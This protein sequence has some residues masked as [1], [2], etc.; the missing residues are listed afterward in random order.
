MRLAARLAFLVVG[1][2]LAV[3]A[4]R[5]GARRPGVYSVQLH[6][7]GPFSEGAGSIDSHSHEARDVGCD[8][9]W[10]SEHD[11]RL[12]GYGLVARFGFEDWQEPLG[13]NEP[14]STPF[15]RN[16]GTKGLLLTAR[17]KGATVEFTSRPVHEGARALRLAATGRGE[18][19]E[20]LMVTFGTTGFLQRRALATGLSV[21]LAVLP[22][23]LEGEA[24]LVVE[25]QLSE[26]APR[27]ARGLESH[28][29]SYE[30]AAEPAG[31][32][33][34]DGAVYRVPVRC[35]PGAWNELELDLTGDAVRG[36]PEVQGE[37]NA[38]LHLSLGLE[39]RNG[40]RASAVF[41]DLRLAQRESGPPVYA[42]Q[43]R[44]L[45]EV[46]AGYDGVVQLQGLELSP[47]AHHLNL[48]ALDT[49]LPDYAA[50]ARDAPP[51]P[52][53]PGFF[54]REVFYQRALDWAVA[55]T[56]ARG[57]LVSYNHPFGRTFEGERGADEA[58]VSRAD[59]LARLLAHRAQGADL[60][61]VGYRQRGGATLDDHLWLW[62]QAALAGLPLVGIGVSDSHGGPENRW[63]GTPNNFVS[64]V[65]AAAPS[66]PALL[67]G[68]AAGR[69]FFGDLE[70]FDGTL[71]L[72]LDSGARM[73]AC[74]S[75]S[76]SEVALTLRAT[77]T[78]AGQELVLVESGER[79]RRIPVTGSELRVEHRLVLPARRPAFVRCELH[80]ESG[81][82]ALSNPI[83][84]E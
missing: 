78:R 35:T 65:Y 43:A 4:C 46:G 50:L 66:K 55:E 40:G 1:A 74:V 71:E 17:P 82:I 30:L 2:T 11:F 29:L 79:T 9:L 31:A 39:A 41:D 77:G 81:P 54:D 75:E 64:W 24:R 26:H 84:F 60:L 72:E 47:D 34:R 27:G 53:R 37:D 13:R 6:L 3:L 20:P 59:E 68:L 10:W 48:F 18:H 45:E 36:F 8:V 44:L 21:Q 5:A 58:P 33:R 38:L 16:E 51:D 23:T 42:R 14:W 63:R 7:H 28:V 67:A 49:P 73:G 70:R 15:K 80:D 61:E 62:D 56:H 22:E 76:R 19:F 12:L 57:G 83:R 32:P 52:T 25:V 69:V